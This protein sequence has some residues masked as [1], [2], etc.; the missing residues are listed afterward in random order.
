[1][2]CLID[3]YNSAVGSC[4]AYNRV[5]NYVDYVRRVYVDGGFSRL[6]I[7]GF[8]KGAYGMALAAAQ[9]LDD[10]IISGVVV[11]KYGHSET[12]IAGKIKILEAGHPVP[13]ENGISSTAEIIE[14]VKGASADTLIL[15]LIS[16]GGSALFV[17]PADGITLA[18]K[19][20]VTEA[21]LKSGC[22]INELNA[23]RKCL[24]RVKG[25][26]FAALPYPAKVLSLIISDVLGNRLDVIASGPT[27]ES[28]KASREAI[29]VL[30][31]YGLI[32]K[33][34]PNIINVIN[35][36][37]QHRPI[38][39]ENI[40]IAD[41]GQALTA[42]R[43]RAQ[44]LG[45]E[46][47]II[48]DKLAG[49]VKDAV[50]WLSKHITP[51]KKLLISGGETTVT[52]TGAGIG[53]RNMELA[54]RFALEIEGS[55]GITMLSAGTDGTDGPTDAAGAI[56]DGNTIARGRTVGLDAQDYLINNNS[57]TYFKHVG[58][59]FKPGPTGTNVM[60]IQLML[61]S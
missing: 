37:I 35:K 45:F 25:G 16:G 28:T 11:T 19:Q 33:L 51:N 31:T 55:S 9:H 46:A 6:F 20:S 57:Y 5:L 52:V 22:D 44:E 43:A 26:G 8:G 29:D 30:K 38:N 50:K 34:P 49:D 61:F 17:A 2:D 32:D 54:L 1:M 47:E 36:D 7:T 14:L 59:L 60:D 13:D 4:S 15:C 53:G 42:A 27:I 24:S 39:A 40:I 10:I 18:E 58:G 56:V 48:T 23:V 21:L 12:N 41:L 3:I